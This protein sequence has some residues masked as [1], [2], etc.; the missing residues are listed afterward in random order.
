[1]NLNPLISVIVPVYKVEKY[2]SDCMESLLKQTYKNLEIL[3]VDDGSPDNCPTLCDEYAKQ[4]NRVVVIHKPNGGLASARNA[5]LDAA[6]GD[7]IAFLDSDDWIEPQTY[8][9]MIS[10]ALRSDLDIVCCEISRVQCGKEIERYRFYETG[11]E[12]SGKEV[13][14]KILLDNIGSQVV[15]GLYR[16]RC[17]DGVRF[18]VGR[19]YEDI[20]VVFLAYAAAEKIGFIA[21][22]FYLYRENETGISLSPNPIKPY[23]QYLGFLAHYEYAKEKYPEIADDCCAKTAMYAISTC[24]HYYSEKSPLLAPHVTET[25]SFL[26]QNKKTI[27]KSPLLPKTRKLALS[28]FFFSKTIF[29]MLCRMLHKTGLQKKLHFDVK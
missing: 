11:T 19:L 14:R 7:Y 26:R 4:D 17:W 29:K 27:K 5:G 25:E 8:D 2:L 3:L 9:E 16:S 13:T 1:M 6:T 10:F 20:P 22:P 23:H 24:F 18:P 28:I 12:L 15:K 21:E